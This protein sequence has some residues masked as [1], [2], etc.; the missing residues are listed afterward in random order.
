MKRFGKR[1]DRNRRVCEGGLHCPLHNRELRPGF[2]TNWDKNGCLEINPPC[3]RLFRTLAAWLA[4]TLDWFDPFQGALRCTR[5]QPVTIHKMAA[6]GLL[7]IP[8]EIQLQIAEFTE[9]SQTLKAL[10]VTSRSLRSIA[11]SVLFETLRIDLGDELRGSVDDLLANPRICAAIRFLVLRGLFLYSS[12]P[13]RNEEAQL[14]LIQKLLPEMVGLRKVSIY[15][16]N[17]SKT[18]LDVFLGI[19]ASTPLQ[20]HLR[21]NI[22]PYGVIPT[23]HIRLQ[24]SHLQFTISHP[25]I[26]FYQSMLH[27]SA[28]TLT[29]L[30]IMAEGDGL[31]KLAD[32]NLPFLH[33]L[34]LSIT[35]G[36]EVSRPSAAAFITAQRA[37]RKLDLR[38]KVGPLPTIPLSALP[39]LREL[40]ASP[41]LVNQLVPGRPVETIEV[42]LPQHGCDQDWF[43]EEVTQSTAR[44]RKLRVHLKIA[45]IDTQMVKR[46]VTFLPFLEN[47]WLFV[48]CD[49]SWPFR[50][51]TRT[52]AAY[53]LQ[54]SPNVTEVLTSLRCLEHLRFDLY[55][56]ETWSD[57]NIN[58]IAT[59]IATKLRNAN[60]SFSSLEIRGC[61]KSRWKIAIS[62]WNEVFGVFHQ[63][64]SVT[65]Q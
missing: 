59:E 49:V 63:R 48:F 51:I 20:V 61:N 24:I 5:P 64:E 36:N 47:L 21:R 35:R 30:H 39:N 12:A 32:I 19:A 57:P 50:S 55:C 46:M 15:H 56:R 58:D 62:V 4:W 38:G 44:V 54:A 16:L 9:T 45:I 29:G 7:D 27:A 65:T 34:T 60:S 53:F 6:I 11:Q 52:L 28:T 37:I 14:S 17:L 23:P 43:G 22:Y 8:P 2:V 18:F 3:Y 25:P 31:M 33:D 26:E 40:R 41:G 13:P 42:T 10:S 1:K